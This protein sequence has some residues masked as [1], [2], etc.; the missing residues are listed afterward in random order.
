MDTLLQDIKSG[1]RMLLGRPGFTLITAVTLALGIGANT[2]IFSITDKLLIRSLAVEKP[3]QLVLINSVSVSPHFVSNAFSY[4]D[5]NDYRAKNEVFDGMFVFNRTQLEL[6]SN[7]QTE[8]V[9]SEYVSSNYFKV[10]GVRP[11][12]GSAFSPEEDSAASPSQVVVISDSFWRTHFGADPNTIGRTITLNNFPLTVIGV[13][14]PE[15]TGM[16]LEEPAAIWVPVRMHEQLAQSK[17]IENR[18]DH[19]LLMVGRIKEGVSAAQAQLGMDILAQQV[20]EANTPSGVIT[21]GLPFSEQHIQFEPGGQ[22][23]SILRKKF[24]QPLKL[25]MAVVALVLLI[26]CTNVAGLLLARGVTRRKEMAIRRALGAGGFRLARQLMTESLLLALTGG[27]AG[28]LLAPWLVS[29]LIKSQT[30]LSIAR[31]ILGEG[32]DR[33]VLLFS[34][35]TTMLAGLLFGAVPAWQGARTDLLPAMKDE[36]TVSM[37]GEHRFNVRSL[38]VVTQ[39]ALAVIVLIGAGLCIK[40]LQ[41]LLAIDPGYQSAHVIMSPLELDEKK[42]DAGRAR[43]LKDQLIERLRSMPA[44]DDV[45]YGLVMPLSGSRYMS[46]IFVEGRK[47][48]PDEQMAFDMNDVG[49]RYHE[50][51]GIRILEGRGFTEQDREGAPGVV[52]INE[53]MSRKLFPG[54]KTIGKRLQLGTNTPPLEIVGIAAN[55]KHHDLT[56]DPLPHFDLPGLQRKS[57][58]YTNIVLRTHGRASDSVA[59]VRD[60]IRSIDPSLPVSNVKTMSEQI[61]NALSAMSLAST[62]VGVFGVVA[63]MLAAIGLYG[64][65]AY[66]VA[67]RTREIGIRMALGAQMGDVLGMIIKQGMTLTIVGV[68]LGLGAAYLLTRMIA[69]FLYGVSPTDP[70]VFGIISVVLIGVALGACL[71]PARRASRVDPMIALRYQ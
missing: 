27:A 2:A 50:A 8:L 22:G 62:L 12:L 58:S 67:Q 5:F 34:I 48:L 4:P 13:A 40:S 28:L 38:L 43:A 45:S 49:P 53:A 6:N 33:R 56:E 15:F 11:A 14:P 23:I 9:E 63:L 16:I 25:L 37:R 70:A 47:P 26:A 60:E 10:L 3:E 31:G 61:G 20:K 39:L 41:K 32:L 51:M 18:K 54:E 42:Y 7:D 66:A 69:S 52:I 57:G 1:V 44:V 71:V 65:M 46:S 55:I 68:G 64:V 35:L 19:F 29:L 21:K 30:R 59:A 17:F 36:G 24:S